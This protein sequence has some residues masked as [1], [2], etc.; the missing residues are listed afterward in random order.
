MLLFIVL[1]FAMRLE[2]NG[3]T[4]GSER[5]VKRTRIST[6]LAVICATI[7]Q[8]ERAGAFLPAQHIGCYNVGKILKTCSRVAPKTTSDLCEP[9][10]SALSNAL[11][12]RKGFVGDL[13]KFLEND[14]VPKNMLFLH[15]L[16]KYQLISLSALQNILAPLGIPEPLGRK[17]F[18]LMTNSV[19]K[20]V[21]SDLEIKSLTTEI[22]TSKICKGD[23]GEFSIGDNTEATRQYLTADEKYLGVELTLPDDERM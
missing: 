13:R 22:G 16:Y 20:F 14:K 15:F 3:R 4:G 7:V 9:D 6:I 11:D 8:M 10:T 18:D 2:V 19:C 17:M 5:L 12:L 1:L 23:T 21:K